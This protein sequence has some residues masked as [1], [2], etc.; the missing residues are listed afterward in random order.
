MTS[1]LQLGQEHPQ[2]PQLRAGT[3]QSLVS[4]CG[5]EVARLDVFRYEVG[6]L[7]AST[8]R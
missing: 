7:N 4:L 8:L 5:N 3:D 2:K 6:M 1:G